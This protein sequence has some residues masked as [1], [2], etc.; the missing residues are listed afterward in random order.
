VSLGLDR[1]REICPNQEHSGALEEGKTVTTESDFN[2]EIGRR[3]RR[4][5]K[6]R[7]MSLIAV[8]EASAGEFKQSALGSYERGERSL[9]IHRLHRLAGIYSMS[10]ADVLTLDVPAPVRVGVSS[11]AVDAPRPG[12]GSHPWVLVVDD[13]PSLRELVSTTLKLEGYQTMTA[14]DGVMALELLTRCRFDVVV[15]DAVMPRMDGLTVLRAIRS[16][17]EVG[18]LPVV[19][20]SGLGEVHHLQR[21]VD[22]GANGYLTKPFDFRSLLEQLER[23]APKDRATLP[24]AQPQANP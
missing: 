10:A 12:E 18:S 19:M 22:A 4:A 17:P 6:A 15:L 1:L 8:E 23:L 14:A 13:D 21:G 9:S 20:L 16:D 7:G 2:R 3:L 5:R 11:E 24:E